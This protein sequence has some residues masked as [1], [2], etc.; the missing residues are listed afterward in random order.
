M[1]RTALARFVER[2]SNPLENP[3][4]PLT[5]DTLAQMIGG[6]PSVTGTSVSEDRALTLIAVQAAVRLIASSAASL[7]LKAYRDSATGGRDEVKRGVLDRP[8]P[9][10]TPLEYLEQLYVHLLLWGN[11]FVYKVRG[12]GGTIQELWP[13]HPRRVQVMYAGELIDRSF[14]LQLKPGEKVFIVQ[15]IYSDRAAPMT[16]RDIMHVPGLGYDGRV[17]L[18]PIRV[19]REAIGLGLAAEEYS[20]RFFGNGSMPAGVLSVPEAIDQQRADQMKDRWKA[21]FSGLVNAH[22]IAILD[23]NAKFE[24]ISIPPED[25]QLLQTRQFSVTEIARLFG[26]P[27]HMIG[28]VEKSTSWGT[29]IQEQTLGFVKFTLLNWLRRVELRYTAEILADPNVYAE[30]LVDG[31]LRG[32]SQERIAYYTAALSNGWMT[33]QEVREKENLPFVDDPTLKLFRFP[34][35]ETL[36]TPAGEV[37]PGKTGSLAKELVSDVTG[38]PLVVDQQPAAPSNNGNTPAPAAP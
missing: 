19:A 33:G 1:A 5:S 35:N 3:S 32:D 22:E 23:N 38:K 20:A 8:N 11:A 36:T 15:D 10:Q 2:R 25:A 30:F 4:V 34:S 18:P 26:I 16:Q 29:G 31:L 21:R 17:G 9:A 13:I 14:N 7:P 6:Q 24:R 12:V 37:I 27:P 28:D